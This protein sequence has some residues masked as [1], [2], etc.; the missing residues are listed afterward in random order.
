ML[1]KFMVDYQF[2]GVQ[3]FYA[4]LKTSAP[5]RMGGKLMKMTETTSANEVSNNARRYLSE[6][7]IRA[8]KLCV[9]VVLALAATSRTVKAQDVDGSYQ[10]E[11]IIVSAERIDRSLQDVPISISVISEETL[12]RMG[13]NRVNDLEFIVPNLVFGDGHRSAEQTIEIRGLG[14]NARN[15][16]FDHGVGVYV[17]GVYAGRSAAAIQELVEIERVEVLRGPQGTLFGKNTIA[18]AISLVTT[19]PRDEFEG[20]ARIEV[21]NFGNVRGSVSLNIPVIDDRFFVKAAV[22]GVQTDGFV[23][24]LHSDTR[25]RNEDNWAGRVSARFLATEKLTFDAHFGWLDEDRFGAT[26]EPMSGAFFS[27]ALGTDGPFTEI[28]DVIPRDK[29]EMYVGSITANYEFDDGHTFTYIGSISNTEFTSVN[30]DDHG[31]DPMV[32]V[33][34]SSLSSSFSEDVDQ[35]TQEVQIKSPQDRRLQYIA[36]FYYFNQNPKQFRFADG[37]LNFPAGVVAPVPVFLALPQITVDGEIDNDAYA[38]FGNVSYDLTDQLEVYFG[39]RWT[40][41]EKVA[42]LLVDDPGGFTTGGIPAVVTLDNGKYSESSLNPAGGINYHFGEDTMFYFR[43]ATGFKSGGFNLDFVTQS[44][45]EFDSESATTYEVGVKTFLFDRRL[46]VNVNG[47]HTD[48]EDLQEDF[49]DPER[50]ANVI[51]NV[52]SATS[53]GFELELLARPL[54]GLDLAAGIGYVNAKYDEFVT[55]GFDLS[56]ERF[57]PRWTGNAAVQYSFPAF[58]RGEVVI[59]GEVTHRGS[60][61]S[62][63]PIFVNPS[64]TVYNGRIGFV[65]DD[66]WEVFFWSKNATDTLYSRST[67]SNFVDGSRRKTFGDPRTYGISGQIR[68]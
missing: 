16:G 47:F 2:E 9:V 6:D 26:Q 35:I 37:T 34:L 59:R 45:L 67:G 14:G 1:R 68:F 18:G 52:A 27:P 58:G 39:L 42:D 40:H 13:A 5:G 25:I 8:T 29:R 46:Q 51:D 41:E 38:I 32:L 36:G 33:G 31:N 57:A 7:I 12:A 21:G 24:E 44:E 4:C 10:L 64:F 22:S 50:N 65:S 62:D 11:E 53:D 15:I 28:L 3:G 19:K 17:D 66:G 43:A 48:F 54:R 55:A 61:P 49:Q 20:L 56:G 23:K 30:D 63:T 60:E